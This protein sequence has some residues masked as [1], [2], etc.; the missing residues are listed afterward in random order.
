[1]CQDIAERLVTKFVTNRRAG[2]ARG[3][4]SASIATLQA[5]DRS[6]RGRAWAAGTRAGS[7]ARAGQ[8][9]T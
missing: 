9:T 7:G 1:M 8:L 4:A 6:I 3:S 5:N 2:N